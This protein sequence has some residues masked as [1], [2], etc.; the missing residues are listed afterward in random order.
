MAQLIGLTGKKGSGK[1][2]IA[3]KLKEHGY[4]QY[5][6][7]DPLKKGIQQLYNLSDEQL[8]D[9]TAKEIEDPRWGVTP[10]QL[11]QIIGT[12]IFQNIIHQY[13]D[14]KISPK[15]HWTF[16]FEEW[17]HKKLQENPNI[18][19]VVS[20]IRFPHELECIKALGGKII[21]IVRPEF[22]H[23]LDKHSS[24]TLIDQMPTENID[25]LIEND[26]TINDLLN[27]NL[28]NALRYIKY[29]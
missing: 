8:Y 13:L 10:R 23:N 3:I 19:V 26:S 16:L 12:E 11:F 1:D 21:K 28:I 29:L 17:Y 4:V 20:D 7:A 5:A 15:Q 24:E 6:F 22:N 27:H 9:E 18:K 25:Y 2:T 14:L